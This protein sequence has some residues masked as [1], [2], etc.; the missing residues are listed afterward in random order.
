MVWLMRVVIVGQGYV[1]LPL[2]M[3]CVDAG[4]VVVGFDTDVEKIKNLKLGISP[5]DDVANSEVA[6]AISTG[7]YLP[8][9]SE[10]DRE[11]LMLLL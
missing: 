1:G 9:A 8:T 4:Y 2:A 6:A 11:A 7:R 5:I 3:R 10:T